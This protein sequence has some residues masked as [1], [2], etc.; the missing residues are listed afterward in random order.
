MA[1]LTLLYYLLCIFLLA[2]LI[3]EYLFQSK[4]EINPKFKTIF[5]TGCD[6]GVGFALA[7]HFHRNGCVVISTVLSKQ[8][9]GAI[10]LQQEL[11]S[12]RFHLVEL[13]YTKDYEKSFAEIDRILDKNCLELYALINNAGL[14]VMG[15]FDFYTPAQ[16]DKQITVN[17]TGLVASCKHFLPR[18]IRNKGKRSETMITTNLLLKVGS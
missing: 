6:S 2:L 17:F 3:Y 11:D 5:I 18:L 16:I 8:N 10:Q 12:S 4:A 9:P 13:D 1:D 7:K 14:I 15:M